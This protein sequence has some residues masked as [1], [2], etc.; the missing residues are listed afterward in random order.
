MNKLNMDI[1][2]QVV[3]EKPQ[4]KLKVDDHIEECIEA[5][6]EKMRSWSSLVEEVKVANDIGVALATGR[7]ELMKLVRPRAISEEE[8]K[9][10]FHLI[11]VLIETN[12]LLQKHA[13]LTAKAVASV[14]QNVQGAQRS[15][16]RLHQL[17]NFH[18]AMDDE[19]EDKE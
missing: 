9:H 19:D 18:P 10:L 15:L 2:N 16:G 7:P 6:N 3:V 12:Q 13:A 1:T 17:A 11:A 8:S 4:K 5:I 14:L